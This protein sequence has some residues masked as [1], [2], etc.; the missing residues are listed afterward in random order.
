MPVEARA[1]PLRSAARRPREGIAPANPYGDSRFLER[2]GD[3]L[4]SADVV[5]VSVVP[6][7]F[8]APESDQHLERLI[9]HA[10]AFPEV[11]LFAKE[12]KAHITRDGVTYT[13]AQDHP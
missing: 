8:S 5:V 10:G 6:I 1:V 7:R 12:R 2:A 11:E 4:H 3:E 13:H 9:Q